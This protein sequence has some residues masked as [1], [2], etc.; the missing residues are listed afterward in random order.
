M[1]CTTSVILFKGIRTVFERNCAYVCK[2]QGESNALEYPAHSWSREDSE[3]LIS[4]CLAKPKLIEP[5]DYENVIVQKKT[6][7]L[8]DCLREMLLFPYDDFQTAILR[9]QGRY[10]RSTVPVNA[11]EEAQSLFVTE[12]IKT[13]NSDWHLVTYK[14]EDYSGEF[15]QLPSKVAKL[16]KLPIHVYEVDEEAD[17]D[18]DA[19]SLGSQKGGI[20]KHGWLYKGNMNSA[21]SVTMRSFK[22]RFF[23]LIQLGDGSYN[24]NFYK[25]EKI[26]KEPKGSIFLDS[27]MGVIQ[28]NRVRRFA[29]ELKMQDK[30]SYLLAADSEAEMEEW[31]TV[32]NKILQLNFEAA[33]QEKR[34]GDSHEDDEQSKLEGS[35]SGLDSYLPELAKSTREAEIKLKNESRVK[36][37]YLDPDAQKLDFSPMEPEVKP[38][39]EKF[40]KRILVKC[41][42]LSFNL[43]CCVA[44]NEE[45]P[46]TNVEPFFVTLSLF[47]IKYNRKISADF[48]VDLNHFSVRQMLVP[49]SPALMNGGQ[50]P[51]AFQD[52]LQATAMQYPKQ[53][54][55]SVTCPHPDIFLVA[56]IEKVL[57]GSI[58]HCAEP[59]MK[60]S[61]SSKV[62]QKVLK[63]AKQAC[64]RLGQYRMPFA[65]AARTLFKDTSGNLDKNARFS[66]IYRQDSNKLSNDDMLKLLA[67]FRK[68]EKMAKLPVILGNLDITIDNVS[69]DCPNYLNSSYVPMRQFETCSKSPLTF[70]VEEFVPCIPKHTQPYTVYSNHLYVYPKYLKY[71][72]QKSFAKARNIAICIEFKD[73]DEEDSQP[74]KCIYGRPGGPV[75]T[76]SALAAVLHHQQNPEFYDEIKIELPTQLHEKHHLLFTFFHVSCD[77]STKGSTKKKDAVETQVGYSW[78]PLLKDGRVVT[79]EQHVPVSANLPSG[80]LGYQELSMGRHYGPEI[81]WVEGGKPLLKVST[82]LV[83]TVYTQDQHLHN[84]FQYC[85]KTESGA[86]ASGSELVKYL[87]SLHAMEGHV[88]IAFLPTILNQLFR[89]LTRATQEEVAVN[90]TRVIIHVVAQC[91]EEGLESHLRSYV[92]FAYK[93]EPYIASEYKTV[94]EELTKSMTTILKPSA[95]FLTSN[96]LLKYS[97]FFFDVLIKSMAQHLIENNKVKLLRNQRFPASYHHAVETVVNMLMP[98][99]TQKFR[100]NPEASKNA[101]H[102]LAVFI[103]RCFTFMDRGF[104]FKQINNYISCFAPG[105]PKTLFEYK[106]EFLRVVCNHEHYIPLNLPMPFGKG[107][108][109]RYQDLQLDYS[110]TD[111]FCRNHFLVGL[112]LREVGTALQEFREVR[113][114]A[115]SMLKNLLIKHSFDDRYASRSHQARIASLYLPL[116][117]LLIENVQRI[118]VRDV[119]PFPANPG[120]IVKDEPLAVPAGNPLMTPQKGNTLDHSLHKDLLGAISGIASPYTASTPN[121][122][123]VRNADSRGSLISTDSGNSLPERNPEKSNS[124][125]KHQP[126]GTL[127]NPVV[128]CDKLDQSE[129]KSLLM[130]FLYVLKSMSDDA[131][132]TYWNK[133]S[134]AELMDFFTISEVC[135]HQFQYMGKRY[136]ARTGMMHARLQQL[137]SLDNSV[138]FN[139]SYGHSEAD[140]LH[141]SLLEANIATEVCLTTLDTLS[142]FTLAFKNQ[143][144][145]DHGHNPLMK[146]VFDV[147]LCF[148]QKHQSEMALKNVFTALRSLIYKFPSTFYEGRADM[149]ASL[150]Y[151]VLKCCNS[152]LGSIR[153]DASQLLYFLMRNNFDYTGKKSFVRTHLQVI[154][155]V[156]QLIAD[157]VGI[158]GTRFQQSLSIINNC[159]NSDRLIKHTSF[160]SDVKDLTK[161]IRTVLMAT[162]QMKEHEND[163]E[164]LVDLQYSLAKSYASTPELRKTWLDSM[165][166]IHVKNGDLSEAAMCY[167]HVTALVAE[168]LTRKEADLALQREPSVFP[169]SHNTSKRKSWGGMF[170][171]GCTAFR[172]ITP[173]IDEEAAMMEDVGMQD[174]HFNED[175]LMELLEQCA[176]GLWK[177]E[178][179]ELIAD[180]YKLIIPIYE[181]RRDFERL[182]HL[183]DTLHRAYSKVT[184][185]MHSGRR[186]LGTYFRV[187]FFGQGFFED[188]D[189]K[190]YIYKEP[191]LTPL[192]EISQRLLKLYSDK[193]G[194]ENVKMIQD[195]G[196]VNP[197]DLDSKFAYIQVTHVTPFFDEKELQERRTEFERC[198][199]IRRF[200]FEMPFT[201]TGKRQGGV[202]E[203]C[204]RR[205]ILT[206]IHC[207]PYVKKRIPVM[208]QHHTDLNPIEV[209]IDEMSKKVAELRQLCSSAEVDMIKLQ[210]KLQGSV[211]VQV[212]AG[213][214]AYARAFLDDT[215][216]KRYPDNKVKLLKEVFRQFVEACGQALAVNERLIKEDQLEYQEEMKANYR[217]MAKELSDIMREQICPLEEKTSVLPN[218]LHIFNAISGTPTGTV[219]QGLTS[220]S[221]IA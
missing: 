68:P 13:Y 177:A 113:V 87:K 181:K 19:A 78:L 208:Y 36:L 152:K 220:S 22:R 111:E 199:N 139:H 120:N 183:Y 171:Q 190:E 51:P 59:Y 21:I 33:M 39:A 8:N 47:D 64:Q 115:V 176:D 194:S 54:I 15:R 201:Q 129:I 154:I 207:F 80:Y 142:L 7:I 158:G 12:C 110:L 146:K 69:S 191:K 196:K 70:E 151:E 48:H 204:K 157:V 202:E 99:I 56:R 166:R 116:F 136:I 32:L 148:L 37:F 105:D 178:R 155:S 195:S 163:P 184:E 72:S 66:A 126:S 107:R 53:G 104:V 209:A 62:A 216:T 38:F 41:N 205:T 182:A 149:C 16:D 92:K 119:S 174:V 187:A 83:S 219:V 88:M 97:W 34:N 117:G 150:C 109:Q 42:D 52:A 127:G 84:F 74:L 1:G 4:S 162:A 203:Q 43:Q 122:N 67:D 63:N 221:S 192:S 134:T 213:P 100:D 206:A 90:V 75:F 123:S 198:H 45:G 164:M 169:Y 114:I 11:E 5:L 189:G 212:N 121:I 50:S 57:Q 135:L 128:R 188:E 89:V 106:F 30:S 160:A 27:C 14:Y 170:R 29:F 101:N 108:I 167:V 153:T 103:K 156:S 61:D 124:L 82:H 217:E 85:Q 94:H 102:S 49:T 6:Q 55:F 118:N 10:V 214:L 131:L 215:N 161:R 95:D 18:E 140:V 137:G 2:Q 23:H 147:Y 145:A 81:K 141:Q 130:C 172:V 175:V 138:T 197:K 44:E 93:A 193:F 185:V 28:N 17:K 186:L 173:N 96:K 25:D 71:D 132:F 58:A 125:D 86:Q 79:S 35:G 165:A 24:L 168:Y 60:S 112:L 144:L 200:M 91:H 133:A 46:T 218:S 31:V 77:N 26:S 143:L 65:W 76:R 9:R 98:H 73:S 20:T 3:V 180:I 179:Y 40:G 211:S 159:A 210:L